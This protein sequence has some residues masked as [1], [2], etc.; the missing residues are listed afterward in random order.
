M[1]VKILDEPLVY[2]GAELSPLWIY[3]QH[4]LLG[5]AMVAWV[6]PCRVAPEHMVDGEDLRAGAAIGGDQM[7]HLLV[8][9]FD[10]DLSGMVGLQRL[11]ASLLLEV[12]ETLKPERPWKKAERRGDDLYLAGKKLNI[13]IATSSSRSSLMHFAFNA[14]STGAPIPITSL[15]DW[16]LSASE[17]LPLWLGAVE[18]EIR[19]LRAATWKVRSF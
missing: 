1:K 7:V 9:L 3:L 2:T 8:E 4:G 5:D 15:G 16:G 14:V 19:S 6:G 13:S 12:L 18:R 11:A 17:V 10:F